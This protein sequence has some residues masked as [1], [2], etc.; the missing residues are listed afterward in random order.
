M[1]KDN[2]VKWK[3]AGNR[4]DEINKPKDLKVSRVTGNIQAI[5]NSKVWLADK[6][7]ETQTI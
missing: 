7:T 2:K 4:N 6:G 3:C 1:V 5:R